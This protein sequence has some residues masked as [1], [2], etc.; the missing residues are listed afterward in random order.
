VGEGPTARARDFL[1][2]SLLLLPAAAAAA[3]VT[4]AV[5]AAVSAAVTAA[6]AAFSLLSLFPL[7]LTGSVLQDDSPRELAFNCKAASSGTG[8]ES[9]ILKTQKNNVNVFS[10]ATWRFQS[11]YRQ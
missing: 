11:K 9:T 1:Q 2:T 3:A 8:F 10:T 4:A 7:S 5:T 6:A